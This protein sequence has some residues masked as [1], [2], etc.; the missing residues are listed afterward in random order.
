MLSLNKKNK[1]IQGGGKL[2]G[3]IIL[4]VF[5]LLA[6]ALIPL[7]VHGDNASAPSDELS[8]AE[9]PLPSDELSQT[10]PPLPSDELSQA[11]PPLP[12][13][14]LSQAE[15][16][17]VQ[18]D[19]GFTYD[20]NFKL[21][22]DVTGYSAIKIED[23][24]PATLAYK[25][26][27][28]KVNIDGNDLALDTSK[29]STSSGAVS[30]ILDEN[31]LAGMGGKDAKM[32]FTAMGWA[33]GSEHDARLYV[34]P[35]GVEESQGPASE[36]DETVPPLSPVPNYSVTYD[37]NGNTA[38]AAPVDSNPYALGSHVAVGDNGSLVKDGHSFLG[39]STE[40]DADVPDVKY[41]A[42]DK[43][44]IDS[45]V[46]LYAVWQKNEIPPT[47]VVEPHYYLTYK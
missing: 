19:E 5:V 8:Q 37:G 43:F 13:D 40:A 16:T 24:L 41:N 11:E 26:D 14:E 6:T 44:D 34:T 46:V 4:L 45:D 32:T 38:G 1:R 35:K 30:Y 7:G 23:I 25:E 20:V 3:K 33:D 29:I 15:Q 28:L 27:S 17:A 31:D 47:V 18:A 39:W 2:R 36:T 9:P 10:E 42:G 12:A 21:P 22:M